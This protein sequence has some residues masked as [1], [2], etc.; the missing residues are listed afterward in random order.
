[1]GQAM[2]QGTL[3]ASRFLN[4][5]AGSLVKDPV[6]ALIELV[7]NCWDAGA[8][9]VGIQWPDEARDE[10]FSISDDGHGMTDSEFEQ[11]W[12]MLDYDRREHQP[13]TVLV[14][15]RTRPVFGRNG[16]GR[17]A[18]FLFGSAY[19][20]TTWRDG[21]CHTFH[22]SRGDDSPL[23]FARRGRATA[24]GESGTIITVEKPVPVKLSVEE[25]RS[26]IGAR[27]LHDPAFQVF[28][29]GD[30]VEFDHLPDTCLSREFIT[31]EGVGDIEL[32]VIDAQRSDRTSKQ[33]GVSW[34]VQ[35]RLV[36][37]VSWTGL[38]SVD[39][40]R[41]TVEAKRYSFIVLADVLAPAVQEDW[42]GFRH[43]N[44]SWQAARTAVGNRI[45]EQLDALSQER[46]EEATTAAMDR[47]AGAL[48]KMSRVGRSRWNEFVK[49]VAVECKSIT[50]P[51]LVQLSTILANLE[52]SRTRYGLVDQLAK[53]TPEK[54]DDLHG[55][56][57][58]WTIDMAREVLDEIEGRLRFI[59]ELKRRMDDATTDEVQELQPLFERGLWLFGVEFE[60]IEFTSNQGMTTVIQKLFGKRSARGSLNRPDFAIRPDSTVGLYTCPRYDADHNVIGVDKL[61]IVELKKPGVSIGADEKGEVWT[62]AKELFRLGHLSDTSRVDGFVLGSRIDNAESGSREERNGAVRIFPMLFQTALV[63]AER[64][65]MNLHARVKDAPLF[66]RVAE[67]DDSAPVQTSIALGG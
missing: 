12:R 41:R 24:R 31:I 4:N 62:Y 45:V 60:S 26:Q 47:N 22:V 44:P 53:L 48:K 57:D 35:N 19:D 18:A 66:K 16:R 38:E 43:N 15:G 10:T 23:K 30:R 59:D 6:A 32:L 36:G 37:D 17:H 40:D 7:A 1:M 58:R 2:S 46:R 63:R 55:V 29:N 33:H 11:R 64:R 54:L 67:D 9:T 56:L 13:A 14:R 3:F 42:T 65:M 61:V 21:K 52:V 34:R 28:V 25:A 8:T 5:H 50:E 39:I 27:F 20:V 49:K 51:Q